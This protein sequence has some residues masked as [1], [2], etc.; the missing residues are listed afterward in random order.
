[1]AR[2]SQANGDTCESLSLAV[3]LISLCVMA[4]ELLLTRIFSITMWYHFAFVAIS[5]AMFGLAASGLA[6]HL[7]PR[8][9]PESL[10]DRQLFWACVLF[11]LSIPGCLVTLLCVPFVPMRN[12]MGLFIAGFTYVI[13]ACPFILAGLCVTLALRKAGAAIG[14]VYA[15]D[16][17]GAALGCLVFAGLLTV[18]DGISAAFWL[19]AIGALAAVN[20]APVVKTKH[21]ASTAISLMLALVVA[22]SILTL[23]SEKGHP[24][25]SIVWAK[26]ALQQP[27]LYERWNPFSRLTVSGDADA[28]SEPIIWAKSPALKER[29]LV[30]QLSLHLDAHFQT[31]ITRFDGNLGRLSYLKYDMC[32]FAYNL[33]SN[34]DVLIVGAG[35]GRDILSALVFQARSIKAVELNDNIFHCLNGRFGDFTGHLDRLANVRMIVD[36]ARSYLARSRELFDIIQLSMI[37]TGVTSASGALALTEN[38]L[39]TTEA[40][41]LFVRHLKPDG[42]LSCT[43]LF[44]GE[45]SAELIR[46][47]SMA[48]DALRGCGSDYPE[49][50]ILILRLPWKLE[51]K[52]AV[53]GGAGTLIVRREPF[54]PAELARVGE[55]SRKLQFEILQ[56]PDQSA[57]PV[58][59]AAASGT[60][61]QKVCRD[62]PFNLEPATDNQPFFFYVIKPAMSL[63]R[64]VMQSLEAATTYAKA[65][66]ILVEFALIASLLSLLLVLTPA[67][68]TWRRLEAR[69]LAPALAYFAAIGA[70]FMLVEISLMQ[71]LVL[72]LGHPTYSLTVVLSSLLVGG[73][74]GS[75]L[76]TCLKARMPARAAA[77]A[78]AAFAF[79]ALCLGYLALPVLRDLLWQATIIEK[80]SAVIPFLVGL[81]LALGLPLP[82]G[83]NLLSSGNALN[84]GLFP[85]CWGTNG[86]VSV[87]ASVVAVFI[88]IA[89]GISAALLC[90]QAAYALAFL[91]A[92]AFPDRETGAKQESAN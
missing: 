31:P 44:P 25:I 39:Y 65:E 73:G 29:P 47:T 71:A 61:F 4:F 24:L 48:R 30:N 79:S 37:D 42:M 54:S 14:K 21:A 88:A 10:A 60:G 72:L 34:P 12:L 46:L 55:L 63:N 52:D 86:A 50:H 20:L 16:L 59:K 70:G 6:V 57:D 38:S 19:A 8:L 76:S 17:A 15:Y 64:S 35:G 91:S 66:T 7:F 2:E 40:W 78:G 89:F 87:A 36:E 13:A 58:F 23:V 51:D 84:G 33:T 26:G 27:P 28:L 1:M 74:L 22:S 85:L 80:I 81:G 43:R 62:S 56:A 49:R 41:T 53:A 69:T 68:L 90:A 32:N 3:L 75:W 5:T 92:L 45:R 82:L 67:A 9:F 77:L 11:A 18:T 83:V